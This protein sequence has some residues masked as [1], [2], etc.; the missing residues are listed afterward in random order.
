MRRRQV[1]IVAALVA[2]CVFTA[3]VGVALR[4]TQP[5]VINRAHYDLLVVGMSQ[6]EVE[7]ILGSPRNECRTDAFVWVPRDG[8]VVSAEVTLAGP[9]TRVFAQ[10]GDR[11]LVW[12]G[13]EGLIAVRLAADNRVLETHFSTVQVQERPPIVAWMTRWL[14]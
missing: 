12:I 10:P 3:L 14:E 5:S 1:L 2:G 7:R 4:L 13:P 6:A 11:E 9:P 8:K